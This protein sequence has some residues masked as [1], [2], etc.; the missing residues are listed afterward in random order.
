MELVNTEVME[1]EV[2]QRARST[3]TRDGRPV[4]F[5]VESGQRRIRAEARV[6]VVDRSGNPLTDVVVVGTGTGPFERGVYEGDPASLNLDRR[7]VDWFDRL[8]LDAQD[9][10]IRA[11]LAANL[12]DQLAGAVFDPVL[13]RIP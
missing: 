1:F 10:A 6:L 2:D 9:A 5:V 13:A 11:A 3:Q 12:S 8:V 7:E 4:T